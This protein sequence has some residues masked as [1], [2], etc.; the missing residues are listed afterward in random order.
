[1][2]LVAC[3]QRIVVVPDWGSR[4]VTQVARISMKLN[5]FFV[6]LQQKFM[7]EWL[8]LDAPSL[9][10]PGIGA[11]NVGKFNVLFVVLTI[12]KVKLDPDN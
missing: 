6:K 12:A 8:D 9:F 2:V 5:H 1:M 10:I 4:P 3:L 11:M 7:L